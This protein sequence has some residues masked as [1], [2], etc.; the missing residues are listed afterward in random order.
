MPFCYN[1]EMG[2]RGKLKSLFY[3]FVTAILL[4][5]YNNCGEG[6]Q[7]L[8][9]SFSFSSSKTGSFWPNDTTTLLDSNEIVSSLIMSDLDND[10]NSESIFLSDSE[11]YSSPIQNV[12]RVID[13]ESYEELFN[14]HGMEDDPSIKVDMFLIDLEQNDSD[15]ELLYVNED[16]TSLIALNVFSAEPYIYRWKVDL[17]ERLNFADSPQIYVEYIDGKLN[18]I[19]GNNRIYE[20]DSSLPVISYSN[21]KVDGGWTPWSDWSSCSR[22]CGGGVQTRARLCSS[23]APRNGGLFCEGKGLASRACNVEE[24]NITCPQGMRL[25]VDRCIAINPDA[26]GQ[27]SSVGGGSGGVSGGVGG[28]SGG[29]SCGA[30]M[31]MN[32]TT[33]SCVILEQTCGVGNGIGT[34]RWNGTSY[35]P[36]T[37]LRCFF[38]RVPVDNRC[39]QPFVFRSNDENRI[40][41]REQG[42]AT[43][44]GLADRY[45]DSRGY[46]KSY[47]HSA[48]SRRVVYNNPDRPS[49]GVRHY[50]Q[51][52]S[53]ITCVR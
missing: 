52:F 16:G 53:S 9:K 31:A 21:E 34:R 49:E 23:P 8:D 17:V 47:R 45:C 15:K 13:S 18:I 6:L 7:G 36:C 12:I 24:C 42:A 43:V 27:E 11:D 38:G 2:F 25:A 46:L 20:N 19:I 50:I 29:G 1:R 3:L 5:A 30:G 32:N 39:L 22:A 44:K 40:S 28:T 10:G 48:G 35:G 33:N 14:I 51:E 26:G 41:V 4:L 37:N